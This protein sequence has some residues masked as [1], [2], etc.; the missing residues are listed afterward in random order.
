MRNPQHTLAD[1]AAV[2]N[3]DGLYRGEQ[4]G[5][6]GD[7]DRLDI[8]AHAFMVAEWRG[9]LSIPAE[10]FTDELASIALIEASAGTMA[11]LRALSAQLDSA[12]DEDEIAPG[13]FVP[14]YVSH[15]SNWVRT[16]PPYE[17]RRPPTTSE[18]IGRILRAANTLAT[19]TPIAPA[20]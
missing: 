12:V 3:I 17:P 7:I 16:A 9:P 6:R 18:V 11:A 13:F 4:F 8:C 19:Q 2:I 20:A 14:N 5:I 10:F 1:L 15:V